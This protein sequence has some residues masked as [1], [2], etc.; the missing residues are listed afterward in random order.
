MLFCA[1]RWAS[2]ETFGFSKKFGKLEPTVYG[3]GVSFVC[4]FCCAIVMYLFLHLC[5][6][7]CV[8]FVCLLLSA[9][10]FVYVIVLFCC[11]CFC[12]G[13]GL[14]PHRLPFPAEG[15]WRFG[16]LGH[17]FFGFAVRLFWGGCFFVL[18][19]FLGRLKRHGLL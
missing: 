14:T 1:Q 13:G 9:Y 7:M 4:L 3:A 16:D 12:S 5:V 18:F 8:V 11:S 2:C 6:V 19:V 17:R 15:A 10:V